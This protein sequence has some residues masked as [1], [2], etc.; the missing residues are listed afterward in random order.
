M[1]GTLR[2]GA[3]ARIANN[4]A[5]SPRRIPLTPALSHEGRGRNS[6]SVNVFVGQPALGIQGGLAAHA[7]GG[8]GLLVDRVGDVAGSEDAF[9]AGRRAERS[10]GRTMNPFASS[11]SCPLRNLVFGVW[12]IAT[13]MPAASSLVV[14][15]VDACFSTHHAGHAPSRRRRALPRRRCSTPASP[16]DCASMPFGHDGACW[17]CS[18]LSRR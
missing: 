17:L 11:F 10:R 8:D 15:P 7:G 2:R 9:D 3:M 16:S 14:S 1:R 12:P 5:R 6:Q 13:N 4:L 18:L